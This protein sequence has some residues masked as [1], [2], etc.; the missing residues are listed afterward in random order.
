MSESNK[1]QLANTL[2]ALDKAEQAWVINLLVQNLAGIKSTRRKVVKKAYREELSDEQWEAYFSGQQAKE[3]SG[4]T[5]DLNEVLNISS[6]KTIKPIEK[7][8]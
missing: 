8:L 3:F 5:M 6:A 4:E 7:W 1:Q 2:L